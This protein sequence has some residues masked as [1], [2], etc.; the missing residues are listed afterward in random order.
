MTMTDPRTPPALSNATPRPEEQ[1]LQ[2][3]LEQEFERLLYAH[4]F[5]KGGDCSVDAM[6]EYLALEALEIVG[7]L[8]KVSAAAKALIAGLPDGEYIGL[9]ELRIALKRL[10]FK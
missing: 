4:L 10:E 3:K 9:G 7:P 5:D 1:D 8:R 2:G 6:A